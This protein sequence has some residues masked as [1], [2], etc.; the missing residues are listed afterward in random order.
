M[1]HPDRYNATAHHKDGFIFSGNQQESVP[2]TLFLDKRL[3]PIERNCWQ[4]IRLMLESDGITALPTYE[5]LRPYLTNMPYADKASFETVAR[6]LTILRLARWLSLVQ[7]RRARDGSKQSNLYVLHDEP[8]TPFEAIRLDDEFFALVC[9]SISHASRAIQFVAAGVLEDIANDPYLAGKRLPTR[10]E[11][12]LGRMTNSSANEE[13]STGHKSEEGQN[14]LLRNQNS[15]TS[16]SEAGLESPQINT[17]RNPKCIVRSSNCNN[18][19]LRQDD[20]PDLQLPQ[21]FYQL[22]IAEQKGFLKLIRRTEPDVQQLIL[23]EWDKRCESQVI[24]KPAAYLYGIV[25]KVFKGEFNSFVETP[26]PAHSSP[27]TSTKTNTKP[28]KSDYN[29]TPE[30]KEQIRQQIQR[31]KEMMS[32]R[33]GIC[34]QPIK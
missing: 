25:Q 29:P 4:V 21:R 24:I 11:V 16:E 8:L 2:R 28:T 20:A 30:E 3:T 9:Q 13:L 23:N 6:A 5:Q 1:K 26:L 12:L 31:I 10:V 32:K 17:L 22:T 7:R 19:I 14:N 34:K 33:K 27:V 15:L 18:K